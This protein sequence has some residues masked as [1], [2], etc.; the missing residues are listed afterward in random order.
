M[1]QL[2]PQVTDVEV[3]ATRPYRTYPQYT[4]LLS[5]ICVVAILICCVGYTTAFS[6]RWLQSTAIHQGR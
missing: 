5:G 2:K 6:Y 3:L 4:E 1:R